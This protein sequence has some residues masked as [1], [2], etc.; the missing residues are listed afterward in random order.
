M[1]RKQRNQL[2]A[3]CAAKRIYKHPNYRLSAGFPVVS[4]GHGDNGVNAYKSVRRDELIE[5]PEAMAMLDAEIPQE[6]CKKIREKK[7]TWER[8]AAGFLVK[9]VA[10]PIVVRPA[11]SMASIAAL[12]GT[13]FM[14]V[15]GQWELMPKAITEVRSWF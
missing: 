4:V 9:K 6:T 13:G 11:L 8:R 14:A 2:L 12:M 1:T 15:T 3:A 5:F 7:S 10:W